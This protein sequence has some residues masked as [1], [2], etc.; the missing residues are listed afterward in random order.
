MEG[1]SYFGAIEGGSYFGAME[2]GSYFGAKVGSCVTT[3]VGST[4]WDFD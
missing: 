1:S 2:G 3:E 4:F